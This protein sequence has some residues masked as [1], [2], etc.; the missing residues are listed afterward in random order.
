MNKVSALF[1]RKFQ[2]L[3][4]DLLLLFR[5][6]TW[7]L[8]AVGESRRG[9]VSAHPRSLCEGPSTIM[10][11]QHVSCPLEPL[12]LHRRLHSLRRPRA[13]IWCPAGPPPLL[14]LLSPVRAAGAPPVVHVSAEWPSASGR[15]RWSRH[16]ALHRRLCERAVILFS[17]LLLTCCLAG[18]GH[19][20]AAGAVNHAQHLSHKRRPEVHCE[21]SEGVWASQ[22]DATAVC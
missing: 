19:L 5:K 7:C 1:Q 6:G 16:R 22:C 10:T 18:V 8:A 20:K 4:F 21:R 13:H 12:R 9:G 2:H 14:L 3:D 17:F 11:R 15:V